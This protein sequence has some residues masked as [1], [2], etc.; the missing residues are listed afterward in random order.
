LRQILGS[1]D[2]VTAALYTLA[3]KLSITGGL[4]DELDLWPIVKL[5]SWKYNM[6]GLKLVAKVWATH[7]ATGAP[8]NSYYFFF[9]EAR[10]ECQN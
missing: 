7:S 2:H 9:K 4:S 1:A 8:S 3:L 6:Q 10:P 5:V